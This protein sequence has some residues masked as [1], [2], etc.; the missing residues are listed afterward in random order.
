M[1]GSSN[2]KAIIGG[3]VGGIVLVIL[4]VAFI[5]ISCHLSKKR[6]TSKGKHYQS[7]RWEIYRRITVGFTDESYEIQNKK[8][9]LKFLLS[10]FTTGLITYRSHKIQKEKINNFLAVVE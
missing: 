2:K 4:T 7:L 10:I 8:Q 5:L 3:S 9:F 1:Q 6:T